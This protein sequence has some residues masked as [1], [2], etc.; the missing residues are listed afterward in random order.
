M[1]KLVLFI[2]LLLQI[3]CYKVPDKIEPQIGYAVQDRYIKSLP[4]AFTPLTPEEKKEQWAVEY[5]IG[6][7][8]A[9]ELDLYR[10]IT[11]FKRAEILLGPQKIERRREI[12]YN[13]L[14]SYY[15]GKRYDET[16]DTFSNSSLKDADST[17]P[18]FR[19]LLIILYECYVQTGRDSQASELQQLLKKYDNHTAEKLRIAAALSTGDVPR[20]AQIAATPPEKPYLDEF[21]QFYRGKK[22]SIGRAGL[23]NAM[24]PG[25]GYLYV[26]QKQSAITAFLLNGASIWASYEFFSR[27]YTAAGIIT[28]S[29]EIGWYF[30]GIYGAKE[31]ARFYNER[32][33]EENAAYVMRRQK[34]FPILMLNYAF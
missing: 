8:F 21:L 34:L 4:S 7:F 2:P 11:A 29:F 31:S 17:F 6:L 30:G 3:S 10:A 26:G 9:Q 28:T 5:Q 23:Y 24:L 20:L 33:F 18:A 27:G 1:K 16:I 22:K 19:D 25:A 32:L 12:D 15:L 14:L 13:I